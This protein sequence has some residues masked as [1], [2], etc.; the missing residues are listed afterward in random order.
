MANMS[1]EREKEF[2]ELSQYLIF[3][4]TAVLGIPEG[5]NTHP[6]HYLTPVPGK[7]TKSQLLSGLRQAANDTIE[8]TQDFTPEQV[9][10]IDASCQRQGV[11]TLSEI[12]RRYWR[13]YKAIIEKRCIRNDTDYYLAVGLL[14]DTAAV[15]M[16][17]A[18]RELLR[19]AVGA[20]EAR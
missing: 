20:Y 18:E 19:S 3:F 2:Q 12:R 10:E 17:P 16:A 13:R 6:R 11:L 14:S 7:I 8:S 15:S 9:A 4:G 5:H 1:P